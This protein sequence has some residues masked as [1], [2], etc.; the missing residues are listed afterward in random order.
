MMMMMINDD[1]DDD[2]VD[3]GRKET[4]YMNGGRHCFV[5]N[6]PKCNC[7]HPLAVCLSLCHLEPT[8]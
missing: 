5:P 2:D 4:K 7:V 3:E 8:V 6:F 1:D